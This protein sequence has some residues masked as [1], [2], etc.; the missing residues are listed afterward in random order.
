MNRTHVDRILIL[1]LPVIPLTCA[2]CAAP[3]A[4]APAPAPTAAPAAAEPTA[5][6]APAAP[7]VVKTQVVEKVVITTPTPGSSG[8]IPE[9]E[10]GWARIRAAG[11]LL[12]GTS[13]GSVP[14][15]QQGPDS[16]L[17]GF[18]VALAREVGRR[19]NLQ[20][21]VMDIAAEGLQD[22]LQLGQVDVGVATLAVSLAGTGPA[23]ST[24]PYYVSEAAVLMRQNAG[25]DA[26]RDPSDLAGRRVGVQQGTLFE[27]WARD[28][29]M[30]TGQVPATDLL[31]YRDIEQ[32]VSDLAAGRSDAIVLDS[33]Q[34]RHFTAKGGLKVAGQG[35]E[36]SPSV[37][38]VQAGST[39]LR[40]EIDRVLAEMSQDG[41][42]TRLAG[43]Y[44]GLESADLLPVSTPGPVGG[45]LPTAAAGGCR[46]GMAWVA[47]LTYADNGMKSPPALQP[48]QAFVKTF[49]LR[50]TGTCVW[51]PGYALTFA[52]G[53]SPMAQMGGSPVQ[54]QSSVP[55]GGENDI[56]LALVAPEAPGLYVGTWEM[57]NKR[58]VAFGERLSVGIAVQQPPTATPRPAPT[59]PVGSF[60]VDRT[61]IKPGECAAVAWNIRNIREVY[62]YAKGQTPEEHGATGEESRS[63]CPASTTTY[64]LR[65]VHLDGS[66]EVRRVTITVDANTEV[67]IQIRLA[68]APENQ[69]RSG[70][71]VEL[72]WEVKGTVDQV[73]I[74]RDD[75]VLWEGAPQAGNL[76]DCPSGTGDVLY[77]VTAIGSRETVQTQ[78][79]LKVVP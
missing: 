9:G 22:A 75:F 39:R 3:A 33:A 16:G 62:F 13:S 20:V 63:L 38:V 51:E 2:A 37:V 25:I 56:S 4:P 19:L 30:S 7:R 45:A 59:V 14:F 5:A 68:T 52:L 1:V 77:A 61:R 64:E 72:S 57:H 44:L 76:R 28:N 32:A 47:D 31:V 8:P 79:I 6:P 35:L 23:E 73:R 54:L 53:S 48:G 49:R 34:A 50:N 15:A 29:L 74:L 65:L 12:A 60:T 67:P 11:K 46:D 66:L 27:A 78:R 40:D 18:D 36:R 43:Q 26:V 58:A 69:V 70:E 24:R 10:A 41:T 42:L 71:C 17:D 55:V 21:Q